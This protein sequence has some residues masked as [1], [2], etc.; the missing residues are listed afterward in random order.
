MLYLDDSESEPPVKRK[1]FPKIFD[2]TFYTIE[3]VIVD[4]IEAR[5]MECSEVR[6]G[7]ISSTGNF[8]NHYKS[9]H[10]DG[11]KALEQYLKNLTTQTPI[12]KCH[13]PT[14]SNV[15]S[16]AVSPEN[17]SLRNTFKIRLFFYL[18]YDQFN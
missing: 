12:V 4:K 11:F 7:D 10:P 9:K 1:K 18:I 3:K 14:L 8:K 2:G 17:V 6:K 13:Q 5:C 16:S 15:I